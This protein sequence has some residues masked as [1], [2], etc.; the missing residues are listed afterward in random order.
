LH[1]L[2]GRLHGLRVHLERTLRGD[3]IDQLAH[4]L[5]IRLFQRPLADLAESFG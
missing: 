3:Q 1:H 4:R 2:I 5:D